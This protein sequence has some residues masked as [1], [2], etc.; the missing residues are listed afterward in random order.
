MANITKN[1]KIED[2][3]QLIE[4]I[5]TSQWLTGVIAGKCINTQKAINLLKDAMRQTPRE[6]PAKPRKKKTPVQ[7]GL[8]NLE[9]P[10]D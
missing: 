6:T 2:A 8:Q 3:I 10:K 7:M 4:K 5:P 1:R 9:Q